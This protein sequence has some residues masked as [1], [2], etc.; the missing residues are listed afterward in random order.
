[1]RR[2]VLMKTTLCGLALLVSGNA[3]AAPATLQD[4]QNAAKYRGGL[5][6]PVKELHR[7]CADRPRT[8]SGRIARSSTGGK[9][10][11]DLVDDNRIRRLQH[12]LLSSQ[13]LPCFEG[14]VAAV[15]IASN[16]DSRSP[17]PHAGLNAKRTEVA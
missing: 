3:L 6:R 11:A 2:Q 8:V 15:L 12:R 10:E 17:R 7:V 5:L 4:C 16:Q 1:M 9:D 14:R 13:V